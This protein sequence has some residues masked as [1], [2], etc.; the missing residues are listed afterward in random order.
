MSLNMPLVDWLWL[1]KEYWGLKI[2][3]I[4]L[5]T[6]KSKVEKKIKQKRISKNCRTITTVLAYK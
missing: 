6:Q 5:P 4:K 2:I 3:S 1:R